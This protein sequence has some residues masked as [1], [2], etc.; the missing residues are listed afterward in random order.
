MEEYRRFTLWSEQVALRLAEKQDWTRL[1]SFL[2]ETGGVAREL[3]DLVEG[4]PLLRGNGETG[5]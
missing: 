4:L 3:V 2:H 1:T 5:A